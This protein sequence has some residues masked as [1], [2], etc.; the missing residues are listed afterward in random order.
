MKHT[1]RRLTAPLC[2]L[3]LGLVLA[4]CDITVDFDWGLP[5]GFS[6]T[7]ATY[8]TNW[9][10]NSGNSYIC[11]DRT[12]TITYSFSYSGQ[13]DYWSSYLQGIN[14]GNIYGRTTFYPSGGSSNYVQV[15]FNV[16]PGTAPLAVQNGAPQ[17]LSIIV[18]PTVI[19]SSRLLVDINGYDKAY[20]LFSDPIPVISSCS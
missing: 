1:L 6:I 14:T 9:Q 10:D 3:A 13:L 18:S 4:A 5:P 2:L 16:P 8:S 20:N 15:S 19:G 7:D 11:D 12:T 17:P